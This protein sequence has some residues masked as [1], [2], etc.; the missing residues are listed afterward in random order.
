MAR[1]S[2]LPRGCRCGDLRASQAAA[3]GSGVLNCTRDAFGKLQGLITGRPL[4]FFGQHFLNALL[5]GLLLLIGVWFIMAESAAA[6]WLIVAVS[7]ALG[8]LLILPI[9]GADTPV[10]VSMLNFYSGW[11]AAGIGF[12]LANSLLIITDALVG[13]SGAIL[14]YIMCK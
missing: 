12:T 4:V 8:L 14:S 3:R 11:A 7:F 6:F 1:R 5:G 13:S 10:V 9:G 2:P